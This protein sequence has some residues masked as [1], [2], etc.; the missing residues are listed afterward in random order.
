MKM[1]ISCEQASRVCDKA[2]YKEAS[3]WQ[4]I[5]MKLHHVLCAMCRIQSV[6]NKKLTKALVEADLKILSPDQKQ[7]I[8]NRLQLEIDRKN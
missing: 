8:K 3:F 1:P 2:Q 4:K 5:L 6:R 7:L